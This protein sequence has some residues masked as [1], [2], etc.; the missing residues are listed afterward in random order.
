MSGGSL[1]YVYCRVNDARDEI[2]NR[3]VALR[4]AH[5][6]WDEME[7]REFPMALARYEAFA[8]HLALVSK[9]LY[10]VEWAISGDTH[11]GCERERVAIEAVLP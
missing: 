2:L 3:C 1:D 9:A 5:A 4:D 6:E 8:D 11:I 7:R 10:E